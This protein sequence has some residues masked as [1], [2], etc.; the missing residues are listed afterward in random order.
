MITDTATPAQPTPHPPGRSAKH[1]GQNT[2]NRLRNGPAALTL[3]WHLTNSY[4]VYLTLRLLSSPRNSSTCR[5][6]S[7]RVF[8]SSGPA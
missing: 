8:C 7:T 4:A 5:A 1:P 6:C 2:I 3:N